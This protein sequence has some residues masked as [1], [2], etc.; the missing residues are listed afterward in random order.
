MLFHFDTCLHLLNDNNMSP[1]VGSL[2]MDDWKIFPFI[3]H[4]I[5][6][7]RIN[8]V[9]FRIK[10]KTRSKL[11]QWQYKV[12]RSVGW[13]KYKLEGGKDPC[14]RN[15][16]VKKKYKNYKYLKLFKS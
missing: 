1:V 3:L 14:M 7:L 15:K 16:M 2:G 13:L 9:L 8:S 6:C 5:E 10:F 12:L 11:C 4:V